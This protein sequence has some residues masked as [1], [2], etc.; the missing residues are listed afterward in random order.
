MQ[1]QAASDESI[2]QD[3]LL[4]GGDDDQGELAY[5]LDRLLLPQGCEFTSADASSNPLGKS[6]SALSISSIRTTQPFLGSASP[7]SARTGEPLRPAWRWRLP[8]RSPTRGG[9]VE[10]TC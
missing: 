4:V 10:R 6:A 3:A 8:S 2:G 9:Q 7:S 5:D 1:D